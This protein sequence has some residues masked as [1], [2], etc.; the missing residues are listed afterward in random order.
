MSFSLSSNFFSNARGVTFQDGG[1]VAWTFNKNTNA[2]TASAAGATA[3]TSVGLA[4][5]S[6]A[7]IYTVSNSP[8]TANGTLDIA[9]KTQNAALVFAGPTTGL[10]AQPTF[11]ALVAGDIPTIPAT[12][13]SGLAVA[14]NPAGSI[15]LA[16]A[17]GTAATWVRSDATHA[18]SQAIVPTWT[19]VHTFGPAAASP[20]RILTSSNSGSGIDDQIGRAGTSANTIGAGANSVWVDTTAQTYSLIQQA[21]GQTELWM[22]NGSWV[23][24]WKV[25]TSHAMTLNTALGVNGNAPPAQSTGWGTPTGASVTA[26]FSGS[27]APL[28]T[29]SAA[30]AEIITILK[31]VGFLGA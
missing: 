4:D 18:L 22:F 1:G 31:A 12:Q 28:T 19:G 27:A 7:A 21:G 24:V 6:S 29:C 30:I 16:A 3:L 10:A 8:L 14:A 25:L 15:G 26:N 20:S 2:I 17:N 11:R 13:V 5:T 23:Q 9:L